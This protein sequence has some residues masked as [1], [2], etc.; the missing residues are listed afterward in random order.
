MRVYFEG[1]L[2]EGIFSYG[3]AVTFYFFSD[4]ISRVSP[5]YLL[6]TFPF[7]FFLAFLLTCMPTGQQSETATGHGFFEGKFEE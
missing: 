1:L 4:L 2:F 3:A 6:S 5:P 7:T